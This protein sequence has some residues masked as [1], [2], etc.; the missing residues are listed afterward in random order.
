[1]EDAI[2]T[3][4]HL[5]PM[6]GDK[7]CVITYSGGAGIMGSDSLERCGLRLSPLSPKTI[8]AVA[9]L[10]PDWMPLSNPLDIWPAVMLH[11]ARKAYSVALRAVLD[12]PNVDGVVCIAIAPLPDFSFLDV[13]EALNGA[14]QETALNKP[15]TAWL[16]GPNREDISRSFEAKKRILTYPT[17]ERATWALSLLWYRYKRSCNKG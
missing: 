13:S 12:D 9:E 3:L 2:R 16:Y 11:G 10:S 7:V 8:G 1:M 4:L 17:I 14:L 15:V 5:P 6:R